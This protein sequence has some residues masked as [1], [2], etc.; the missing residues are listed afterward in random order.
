MFMPMTDTPQDV[1][2]DMRDAKLAVETGVDGL[3]IVIGTSSFLREHSHGKDMAYIEK[4]A[5]EV[6]EYIKSKGLEVRCESTL[7]LITLQPPG[8]TPLSVW[9]IGIPAMHRFAS[10][11]SLRRL[12]IYR[13]LE[14]RFVLWFST[15]T[16][17][18][19]ARILSDPIWSTSC[20]CTGPLTRLAS[21]VLVSLIPSAVHPRDRFTTYVF[22]ERDFMIRSLIRLIACA[23]AKRRCLYVVWNLL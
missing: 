9:P 6:I 20:L 17:Q 2:C 15:D 1:R 21:T 5:I 8:S 13:L 10:C 14:P 22:V 18:S 11:P 12:P 19:L 23:D 4:T 7:L 16:Q 3:D